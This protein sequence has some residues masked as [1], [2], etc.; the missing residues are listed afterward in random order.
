MRRFATAVLAGCLAF[1][2]RPTL[3]DS[4]LYADIEK[5][6]KDQGAVMGSCQASGSAQYRIRNEYVD[7]TEKW[8]LT[9][10]TGACVDG[11]RD[12]A[13]VLSERWETIDHAPGADGDQSGFRWRDQMVTFVGGGING[14]I[15]TLKSGSGGPKPSF[16]EPLNCWLAGGEN[17]IGRFQKEADGR[18]KWQGVS[19]LGKAVKPDTYLPA[20][21]LERESERIISAKNSGQPLGR[22]NVAVIVPDF[23]DIVGGGQLTLA[24]L[25]KRPDLRNKRLAV[26]ISSRTASELERF[27]RMRQEMIDATS[28]V[29]KK[30]ANDRE[31]FISGSDPKRVL[32]AVVAAIRSGAINVTPA[33]DLSVL[34]NH[35]ADYVLLLDWRFDGDFSITENEYKTLPKC[36][37]KGDANCHLL[38]SHTY[39]GW[40]VNDKLE[41]VRFGE[42]IVQWD[43]F[44]RSYSW[45]ETYEYLLKRLGEYGFSHQFNPDSGAIWEEV[46]SWV[47]GRRGNI[48][49]TGEVCY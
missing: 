40:L 42:N 44:A 15:C 38:F 24:L 43:N 46:R 35:Q 4:G 48:C 25:A 14:L 18:W 11:K 13:G 20:G 8:S 26:V 2:G 17:D 12:G 7:H 39:T 37:G 3:A 16:V 45:E 6:V 34:A 28:K 30:F 49:P 1:H 31:D 41:A 32:A 27:A 10:W 22:T 29:K 36:S 33:D 9:G 21:T 5:F 23:G 47:T 19:Y